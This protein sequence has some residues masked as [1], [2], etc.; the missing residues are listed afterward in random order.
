MTSLSRR[1]LGEEGKQIL[2]HFRTV[3]KSYALLFRAQ[4]DHVH[5]LL[6]GA[7]NYSGG[8]FRES[9]IRNFL[10]SVLPQSISV[11]SGFVYGFDQIPNSKQIDILV[12]DSGRH[13]AVYRTR[14]FVIVPPEAVIAAISVKTTLKKEELVDSLENLLSLTPLELTYRVWLDPISKT[15]L[16]RP[17][18][19]IV[20]S[21]EGPPNLDAA[22]TT[23]G[24]FFQQRFAGDAALAGEMIAAF[25]NCDPINPAQE[26]IHRVERVIPKLIAAIETREASLL[27]GWGPPEDMLGAGNYGPGL[28]RLPYMYVQEN[29][30]T[31][32]LEKVVYYVLA[33]VYMA[34]GTTGFSLVSAWG[35]FNPATGFRVGDA[36]EVLEDRGIRL[37]DP[38]NLARDGGGNDASA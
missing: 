14:E 23:V 31:T 21:Y 17:I 9:L 11:D 1:N 32:P 2:T 26:K 35:E 28:H 8:V 37:L 7:H 22:L 4:R 6:R 20:V 25:R 33:S 10:T 27:Q 19:K 38:D 12:W 15:P 34:L 16:L 13:A 24:D 30:L 3:A 5:T 29:R 36:S 18:T